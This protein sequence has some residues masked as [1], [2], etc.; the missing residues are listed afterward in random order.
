MMHTSIRCD[1]LMQL[2]S[3]ESVV[4]GIVCNFVDLPLLGI[5]LCNKSMDT[6]MRA[7]LCVRMYKKN[8]W[9]SPKGRYGK[10]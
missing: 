4:Q 9:A 2:G 3:F 10:Y 6:N 7:S 5:V 1:L 8:L